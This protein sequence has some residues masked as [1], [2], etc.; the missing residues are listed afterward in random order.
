MRPV[1]ERIRDQKDL[2]DPTNSQN[3]KQFVPQGEEL[4]K[5]NLSLEFFYL[6]VNPWE[7]R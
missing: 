1:N 6:W 4:K 3:L 5:T 2:I 7:K